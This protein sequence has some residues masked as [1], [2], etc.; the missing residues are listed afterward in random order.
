VPE[1]AGPG[2]SQLL[3]TNIAAVEDFHRRKEFIAKERLTAAD[4]SKRRSGAQHRAIADHVTVTRL[5]APNRSDDMAID[6]VGLLNLCKCCGMTG[7]N[8]LPHSHALVARQPVEIFPD[9]ADELRLRVEQVHD[10]QIGREPSGVL[11]VAFA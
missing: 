10:P 3:R 5:D 2:A 9:V 11:D 7:E 6:T 1:R 8:R 4:A